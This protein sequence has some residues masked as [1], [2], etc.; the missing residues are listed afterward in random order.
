MK[1]ATIKALYNPKDHKYFCRITLDQPGNIETRYTENYA[2]P[3]R[4]VKDA[5][6]QCARLGYDIAYAPLKS[7]DI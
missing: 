4:A 5:R 3:Q 2:L 1:L 7:F 6:Q